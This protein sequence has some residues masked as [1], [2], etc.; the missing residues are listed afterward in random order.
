MK[1]RHVF[2]MVFALPARLSGLRSCQPGAPYTKG[3]GLGGK[4]P[5]RI[6]TKTLVEQR[7]G[8]PKRPLW[9]Y[10][11]ATR[12]FSVLPVGPGEGPL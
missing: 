6:L 12:C 1:K 3:K 2:C 10:N 11:L 9:F 8:A 4:L 7:M 5:T